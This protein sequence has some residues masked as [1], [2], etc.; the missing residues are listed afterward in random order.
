MKR[1]ALLALGLTLPIACDT[2]SGPSVP[3]SSLQQVALAPAS[4]KVRNE[5]E[6]VSGTV[7]NLCAPAE[8]VAINGRVHTV[9]TSRETPTSFHTKAHT[10]SQGVE[11]IGVTS[12][13]RYRFVQNLKEDFSASFLPPFA[14]ETQFD[15]RT[16]IVRQGRNDNH[17]LRQTIR[18]S[19]P[20]FEF[21]I[22]RTVIECRG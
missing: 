22:I 16:R 19:F 14:S 11:G 17:Y 12:G 20:P 1:C 15:I 2:P 7:F 5:T 6:T 21:E 9:F 3:Q 13:D 10:N 8:A 18:M 4:V